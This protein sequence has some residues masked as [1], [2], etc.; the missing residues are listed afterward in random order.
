MYPE[1]DIRDFCYFNNRK[2]NEFPLR[3]HLKSSKRAPA[4]DFPL[5]WAAK[6]IF[7]IS[8]NFLELSRLR[9]ASVTL[10][11]MMKILF[12]SQKKRTIEFL[13]IDF[14]STTIILS[15][16]AKITVRIVVTKYK[17]DL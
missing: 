9:R 16:H 6:E 3:T 14:W 5:N 8:L 4:G 1:I 10:F 12:L 13:S 15:F 2:R 11:Y 17:S 7:S